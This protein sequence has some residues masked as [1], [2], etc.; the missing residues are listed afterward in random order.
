M[1]SLR[2]LLTL[3]IIAVGAFVVGHSIVNALALLPRFPYLDQLSLQAFFFRE[4]EQGREAWFPFALYHANEH[5]LLFPM[6]L[7]WLD[8]ELFAANGTFLVVLGQAVS[9]GCAA[10]VAALI[11][12]RLG[13]DRPTAL[14]AFALIAAALFWSLH[15]VNLFW[16]YQVQ[17]YTWVFAWM[18]S[19]Q[20]AAWA[21]RTHRPAARI[22]AMVSATVGLFSFGLGIASLLALVVF[23]LARWPRRWS[24]TVLALGAAQLLLYWSQLAKAVLAVNMNADAS[25]LPER[26]AGTPLQLLYL[27]S[28]PVYWPLRLLLSEGIANVAALTLTLGA[29]A[30]S[31]WMAILHLRRRDPVDALRTIT[32][33]ISLATIGGATIV[34]IARAG[35][36][37]GNGLRLSDRYAFLTVMFWVATGLAVLSQLRRHRSA[38][39][40]AAGTVALPLILASHLQ[41]LPMLRGMRNTLIPGEMAVLNGAVDQTAFAALHPDTQADPAAFAHVVDQLRERRWAIFAGPQHDWIGHPLA[42]VLH[43]AEQPLRGF[44]RTAGPAPGSS[45]FVR[46]DGYAIDAVTGRAPEWVVLVDRDDRIAGVAHRIRR[47]ILELL[48]RLPTDDDPNLDPEAWWV[49]YA[50][51]R[52]AVDLRAF[53]VG[54]GV[55]SPLQR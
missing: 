5:L 33:L 7:Y 26:L 1:K 15:G 4:V 52:A 21:D 45:D 53:A 8:N 23:A 24:L 32:T 43:R 37:Q 28:Q 38:W 11:R 29:L 47:E 40:L 46:V 31:G 44:L 12:R 50:P 13:V 19:V 27:L 39:I 6:P 17:I 30:G 3:G 2:L 18:V 42:D 9:L 34:V 10:M 51:A 36:L 54:D 22:A 25:G 41:I 14:A 35:S 48:Y 16:P 20:C 55:A 49:G